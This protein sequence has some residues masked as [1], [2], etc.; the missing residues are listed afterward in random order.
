MKTGI[1]MHSRSTISG[2]CFLLILA[3]TFFLSNSVAHSTPL[4]LQLLDSP[5]ITS[6]YI[7]V[8][9]DASENQFSAQGFPMVFYDGI[10][11]KVYK[12]GYSILADIDNTGE[13]IEAGGGQISI[14]GAFSSS[15]PK[16]QLLAGS[17]VDFGF[18][19]VQS[20]SGSYS[21][22]FEFLWTLEG[23]LLAPEFGGIGAAFG[24]IMGITTTGDSFAADFSGINGTN[25]GGSV[26]VPEPATML[27]IGSGLIGLGGLR[28]FKR[29]R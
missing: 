17:L 22:I 10:K 5:V 1:S 18:Q 26:P 3:T 11:H 7:S 13:F 20:G 12:G 15:A 29:S 4:N 28:R 6:A 9:Y 8:G 19:F 27:L 21:A 14:Q 24:T 23:G 25:N 2:I 16:Q